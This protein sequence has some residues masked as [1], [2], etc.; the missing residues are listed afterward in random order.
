MEN[1]VKIECNS[2][3]IFRCVIGGLTRELSTFLE[4]LEN[5][6]ILN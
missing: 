2:Q 6:K 3:T 5:D 1:V 4:S